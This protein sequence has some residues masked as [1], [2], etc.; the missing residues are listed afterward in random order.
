MAA[1]VARYDFPMTNRRI[2][3]I[4]KSHDPLVLPGDDTVRHACERMCERRVGAVLVAGADRR[5]AG[6]FTG[7]DAVRV[8]AEGRNAAETPL[9]SVMTRDPDT[10]A[11]ERT[12]IEALRAMSDGGYRHLPVV[13]DGK[14]V[15]IVSRGDFQGMEIDRLE[16]ETGLW[17][18]IA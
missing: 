10:I 9:A 11:P 12:A 17:E 15:G 7:R 2:A 16:E 4:V 14:I 13:Q 3:F 6:I 1:N 18:R 8:L 5:L